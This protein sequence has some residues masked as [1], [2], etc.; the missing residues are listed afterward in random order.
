MIAK[1]HIVDQPGL[2]LKSLHGEPNTYVWMA[3]QKCNPG[4]DRGSPKSQG[5]LNLSLNLCM[6][7]NSLRRKRC[8]RKWCA[9]FREP[10][11]P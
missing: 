1:Q 8:E 10:L 9:D 7:Y 6:E 3:E 11:L 2:A 5:D 4:F